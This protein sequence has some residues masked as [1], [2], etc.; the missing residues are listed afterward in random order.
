MFV[1]APVM[2]RNVFKIT[3]QPWDSSVPAIS[4]Y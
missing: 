4:A 2:A 3:H 1:E